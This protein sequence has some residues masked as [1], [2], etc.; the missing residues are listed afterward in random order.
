[1]KIS[2]ALCTFNGE[3]FIREQL[4][5][6]LNQS[7]KVD[8]IVVSD[9][10]S[11]DKTVNIIKEYQQKQP[12]LINLIINENTLGTIQNFENVL[13]ATSGDLIFL[14]DQDDIWISTKVSETIK[15]FKKN[16]NCKLL[17]SDAE[18][19]NSKGDKLNTS[20]WERWGFNKI[21]QLS[22]NKNENAFK[23]LLENDNK[24]TGAT[25]CFHFS[26]KEKILPIKIPL[27]YWHDA[28]IGLN[29]AALNGLCFTDKKLIYYRFHDEQQVGFS[30]SVTANKNLKANKN[31]ISKKKFFNRI[32]KMYPQKKHLIP[33]NNMVESLIFYLKN[34][35]KRNN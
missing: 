25:I 30:S 16:P 28:W 21:L 31:H 9:D 13:T 6:I 15:Y 14:S 27:G 2:V 10:A 7:F 34:C 32:K 4:E 33:R 1:M 29:A 5:S 22:W 19:I 20:L 24:I 8:E 17:F 26:L 11:T 23:S 3:K 18:I 12:G 35:L